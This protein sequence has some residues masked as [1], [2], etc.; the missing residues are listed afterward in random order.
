MPA[1]AWSWT[2]VGVD[3]LFSSSH[4]SLSGGSQPSRRCAQ[5]HEPFTALASIVP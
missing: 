4:R 2:G 1:V 3:P 5:I